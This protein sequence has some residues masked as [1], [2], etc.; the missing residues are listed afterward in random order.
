MLQFHSTLY[1][2]GQQGLI[3]PSDMAAPCLPV[4]LGSQREANR[5][6][7][8]GTADYLSLGERL[9]HG[10]PKL[11]TSALYEALRKRY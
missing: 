10:D 1:L 8:L 5:L 3:K 11:H 2:C 4:R 7:S 6:P 9:R